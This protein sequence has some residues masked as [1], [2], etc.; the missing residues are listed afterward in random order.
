M[1]HATKTSLCD[2][3]RDETTVPANAIG[4]RRPKLIPIPL[5]L[6]LATVECLQRPIILSIFILVDAC[7][8]LF[9][10]HQCIF[11]ALLQQS[12]NLLN[13]GLPIS[14]Y[15]LHVSNTYLI[16]IS[17]ININANTKVARSF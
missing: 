16:W 6:S 13:F 12:G 11:L 5:E 17:I 4:R 10:G 15:C 9:L 2:G 14:G 7:V 8:S 1:S 3:R